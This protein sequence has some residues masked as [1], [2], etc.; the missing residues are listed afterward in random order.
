[1]A[2]D[3]R[4]SA[5]RW[6]LLTFALLFTAASWVSAQTI[7]GR[8]VIQG[9]AVNPSGATVAGVELSLDD[10]RVSAHTNSNGIYHFDSIPAGTHTLHARKVGMQQVVVGLEV[11]ANDITYADLVMKPVA[12]ESVTNLAPV[13]VTAA[14]RG[15]TTAPAGFLQRMATGQ[16]TYITDAD[17]AKVRPSKLSDVMR[18][19]PSLKIFPNGEVYNGRGIVTL[20]TEACAHGMPIYV[21]NVQVGGGEM[22]DPEGTTDRSTS[23]KPDFMSPTSTGRSPIDGIKP[24]DVVGIE[25]YNGP[26]TAPSTLTGSN[27]ACG[28]IFIWT[29]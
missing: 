21:D 2:P 27:S 20:R 6:G 14:V 1:M 19:V 10:L 8:G 17:I 4:V 18:R 9:I 23:R 11:I 28:A 25:I 26:A 12:N 24:A 22:G 15:S 3:R 29:K 13:T 7:S 16:G 5:S